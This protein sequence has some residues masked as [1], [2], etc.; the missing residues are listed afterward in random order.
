[1][2][3]FVGRMLLKYLPRSKLTGYFLTGGDMSGLSFLTTSDMGEYFKKNPWMKVGVGTISDSIASVNWRLYEVDSKGERKEV[4]QHELLA[5]FNM[6]DDMVR[7]GKLCRYAMTALKELYGEAFVIKERANGKIQGLFLASQKDVKERPC[8]KNRY[9]WKI[10]VGEVLWSFPFE[11]VIHMKYPNPLN[12]YGDGLSNVSV[13]EDELYIDEAA[14]EITRAHLKNGAIPPYIVGMNTTQE[15]GEKIKEKWDT[16]HTGP[17]NRGKPLFVGTNEISVTRMM[18]NF[19]DLGLIEVRKHE[20]EIIRQVFKIPPELI[21]KLDNSNRS[22]ITVAEQIYAKICLIPRLDYEKEI[23]NNSFVKEF[24][25]NLELDYDSPE[26]KDQDFMLKVYE[27]APKSSISLNEWRVLAGLEPKKEL[28]GLYEVLPGVEVQERKYVTPTDIRMIKGLA[29]EILIKKREDDIEEV[30][31]AADS[32][33][34]LED[35]WDTYLEYIKEIGIEELESMGVAV[36]FDIANERVTD[37]LQNSAGDRIEYITEGIRDLLRGQLAEAYEA[38]EGIEK[39]IPRIEEVFARK[40]K[41]Y[42]LERIA[43]TETMSAQNF[44]K[45]EGWKQS[46]LELKK[47]YIAAV[48]GVERKTHNQLNRKIVGLEEEF[49]SSSGDRAQHPGGFSTAKENANCRCTMARVIDGKSMLDSKEK[50]ADY[51][52]KADARA[53]E[54]EE[55]FTKAYAKAFERMKKDVIKAAREVK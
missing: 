9:R 53:V 40:M 34:L 32:E 45:M 23:W 28:D 49:I 12:I 38:G 15:V 44:G 1:M 48:D 43:R 42:E 41:G 29:G 39:V 36:V 50:L 4:K 21:G 30:A 47:E 14:A 7:S 52:K 18:D 8:K 46:K 19:K 2:K 27:K 22:T 51:W 33:K 20:S 31:D 25:E 16:E 54:A 24:G 11:D 10:Q 37:Y 3:R 6:W 17:S 13:L 5:L 55:A 35:V 26:P